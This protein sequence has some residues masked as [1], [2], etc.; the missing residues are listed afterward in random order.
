MRII[1]FFKKYLKNKYKMSDSDIMSTPINDIDVNQ[2][3]TNNISENIM[4]NYEKIQDVQSTP[5][6]QIEQIEQIEL[7]PSQ[8]EVKMN[9]PKQSLNRKMLN[10]NVS[11][12]K[13]NSS[14]SL[15]CYIK[16]TIIVFL[17]LLVFC[18][19]LFDTKILKLIPK[20]LNNYDNITLFGLF[21]KALFGSI[22]F[23]IAYKFI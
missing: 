11:N 8:K 2:N 7:P 3:D 17:I 13:C 19:P 10:N 12:K 15:M 1:L 4:K 21:M 16:P 6:E 22:L 9:K 23:T 18:Y 20:T 14:F 5:I